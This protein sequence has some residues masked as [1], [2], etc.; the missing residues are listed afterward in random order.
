MGET[1]E[2]EEKKA[3][4]L[5]SKKNERE[6]SIFF[7]EGGLVVNVDVV[8]VDR[9]HH[10]QLSTHRPPRSLLISDKTAVATATPITARTSG[11]AAA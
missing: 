2:R 9:Q 1:K 11:G 4:R 5:E 7:R 6:N 3:K 8:G 10:G